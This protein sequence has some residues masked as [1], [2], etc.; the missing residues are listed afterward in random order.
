MKK[1][2]CF[3]IL[4]LCV[5]FG[6]F[7]QNAQEEA[8][9][10]DY[11]PAP[12][13]LLFH[14][15]GWNTLHSFTFNYGQNFII[16]GLGSYALV[17]TGIDWDWNRLAVDNQALPYIGMPAGIIGFIL[18]I[19]LPLGLFFYGK[20]AENY[21]YQ[22]AGLAMGQ[23]A[24]LAVGIST[25]MKAF[26][27]RR[28]PGIGDKEPGPDYS[29]DWA[30][31]FMNREVFNGWPSSHTAVAFAMAAAL[32]ELY[33][34]SL[35]LK[36]GAYSYAALIGGGMSLMAHWLSD[37]VAGALVGYAIGKSVGAGYK[38]LMGSAAG[39]GSSRP[40]ELAL[41]GQAKDGVEAAFFFTP[42]EAGL[43]FRW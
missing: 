15:I 11:T 19:G 6:L 29:A 27:A 43:V 39:S 3:A 2:S 38:G 9:K 24:M 26:T 36:I 14:N 20:S 35:G 10:D 25:T 28:S 31:G 4:I 18:P 21:G 34:D 33:P 42:L 32:T 23:A 12:F 22:V 1:R 16:A 13:S 7:G 17:H 41:T 8:P 5:G 30:F 40:G 37:S